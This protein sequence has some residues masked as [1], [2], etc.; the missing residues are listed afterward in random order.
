ME[1]TGDIR[2]LI[3][4]QNYQTASTNQ[5]RF[6][7]LF[8]D[9]HALAT[10]PTL[11][12]TTLASGCYQ[13]MFQGCTQLSEVKMLATNISAWNGLTDWLLDAGKD[14]TTRTL[15]VVNSQAYSDI[16]SSLPDN[17]KQGQATIQYTNP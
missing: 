7:H 5:T 16:E 17:W 11:P 9:C 12:A 1:C 8:V 10:A 3:D 15:T 4:Y 14:V 6:C 13:G 2:T